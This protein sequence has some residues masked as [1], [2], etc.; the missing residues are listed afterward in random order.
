VAAA[1]N[2]PFYQTFK[3]HA[4]KQAKVYRPKRCR[5]NTCIRIVWNRDVN[6][7]INMIL[8]MLWR[9]P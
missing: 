9:L 7:A 4:T 6:A 1:P 8:K 5:N 3:E 2:M